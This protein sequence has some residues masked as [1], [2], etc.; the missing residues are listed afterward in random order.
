[1]K[2]APTAIPG[3]LRLTPR[4]F[5]DDRGFF[6]ESWNRRS[7]A[8]AGLDLEFVQDNHS[9]SARGTLRGLHYQ[10]PHAQGKLVRVTRGRVFD[11]A[12]DLRRSSP[13]YGRW[14]G[15]ELDDRELEM[16]WIPPG[17]AHGFYVLSETADL[18]Y[19]CTELYSPEDEWVLRW[20]DPELGIEWPLIDGRPPVLSP[21]DRDGRPLAEL[22][23]FE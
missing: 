20:D 2:A 22:E 6:L 19:K 11:V 10:R 8:E 3:V 21:R 16:L 1:M 15:V 12:V 13:A 9:R 23:T 5:R 17:C 4:V 7:L 18:V 14:V